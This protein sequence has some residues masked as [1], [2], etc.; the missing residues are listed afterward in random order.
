MDTVLDVEE[1]QQQ[2]DRAARDAALGP[3]DIRAGRFVHGNAA[4]MSWLAGRRL[5]EGGHGADER[6]VQGDGRAYVCGGG[7]GEGV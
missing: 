4:A 1:V 6:E 3:D 7:E 5:G 2:L